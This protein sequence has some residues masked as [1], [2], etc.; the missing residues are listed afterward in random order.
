MIKSQSN[1]IVIK[2][3]ETKEKYLDK[4]YAILEE[5][6]S[7]VEGG[8]NFESKQDLL[9]NTSVWKLMFCAEKLIGVVVYKSKLGLKL[10]A[11]GLVKAYKELAIKRLY[12]IL[13]SNL[14]RTWMEISEG[15]EKFVLKISGVERFIHAN[16]VAEAFTQKQ[17][18]EQ[19]ADGVHYKRDINGVIKTKLIVG[20]PMMG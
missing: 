15:F 14:T 9:K 5:S 17:I 16:N 13:K 4:V 7:K 11:L 8:L 18:I 19:C 12:R 20:T 3:T 10:V 6:Y 1:T 2:R